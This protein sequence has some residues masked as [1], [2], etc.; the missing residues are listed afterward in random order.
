[1][2]GADE[3]RARKQARIEAA[4]KGRLAQFQN[5]LSVRG[6][7][8]RALHQI[9]RCVLDDPP[10]RKTLTDVGQAR[11][12]CVMETLRLPASN[13]ASEVTW[14]LANP[15]RLVTMLVAESPAFQ[16]HLGKALNAFPCTEESP[17]SIL[18]GWDENVPG[19]KVGHHLPRKSMVLSFSFQELGPGCLC[20]ESAW[21]T[22]I[23][24]RSSVLKSVAGGWSLMLRRFLRLLLLSEGG[25]QTSGIP[26]VI[27]GKPTLLYA[28]VKNLLS[29]GDG[30]KLAFQW[31]GASAIKP[32]IRH[33]NVLKKDSDRAG[34]AEHYV[35]IDCADP[36]AFL[37]W[38]DASFHEAVD[39]AVEADAQCARGELAPAELKDVQQAYGL[40]CTAQGLLADRALRRCFTVQDAFR[41]DWVHTMLADGLLTTEAW[42]LVAACEARG[43]CTQGDIAAFLQEGWEVPQYRRH[44]GRALWRV[45]NEHGSATNSKEG[46]IKCKASELLKLCS[47]LRHFVETRVAADARVAAECR[48]FLLACK[49]CDILLLAKRRALSHAD[50][51]A[52]LE[53]V[54]AEYR[55]EHKRVY[56]TARV[57]PKCHWIWDVAEALRRDRWIFDAFII[58]RLHLRTL[59]VADNVLGGKRR[60]RGPS[61]AASSTSTRAH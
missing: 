23:I 47:L 41:Y 10:D 32:C 5:V 7:S 36:S 48:C 20:H 31:M 24:V 59:V 42:G 38:G 30:H 6:T 9:L 50:A 29:D 45:F 55:A 28:R 58:E 8:N 51:A 39:V 43:V 56:G 3:R 22:P 25:F 33:W 35:E 27:L 1:M 40:K 44:Q 14:E 2:S 26:V 52:R 60:T 61:S 37:L 15:G 16:E 18:V 57:K 21:F 49:A 19:N 12:V 4:P 34:H 46:T 17:W 11:F 13:G 53:A 54:L